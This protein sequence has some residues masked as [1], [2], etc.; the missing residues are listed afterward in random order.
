MIEKVHGQFR[1]I[2]D[3]CGEVVDEIFDDFYEAVD[4]KKANLWSSQKRQDGW[5]D[6]CPGCK[7]KRATKK[8]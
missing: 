7:P 4:Y 6:C 2:C 3:N 5:K 1:L 8:P